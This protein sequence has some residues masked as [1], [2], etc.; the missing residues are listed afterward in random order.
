MTAPPMS[1]FGGKTLLADRIVAMLPTHQHYVEPFAG[2]LAVLLA[3]SPSRMETVNDLDG[4]LMTFWRVL[5]ERPHELMRVCALTPHSRTEHQHAFDA[6]VDALCDVEVARL[7]WLK[8][9]QGRSGT[10]RK[11]G[12]RHYVD[13]RGSSKSMPGYLD[14]YV[15][16]MAAAVERLHR[17]SLECRPAIDVIDKYGA[18]P[19][20]CLYVDPPYLGS[21]RTNS[22]YRT[23][24]RDEASHATLLDVLLRARASVV[25]SGYASDLYDTTLKTWSRVAIPT[26]TGQGGT[27]QERIEVIWSNRPIST[28]TLFDETPT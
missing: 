21:T 26:I 11:T 25:L 4:Q 18:T 17:V 27:R 20:V 6:D 1:Y 2:S 19:D 13:P 10:L 15:E 7:T 14:S 24:M 28:S 5:R 22:G 9:T 8:I 3:K 16:R 12:W 23:D